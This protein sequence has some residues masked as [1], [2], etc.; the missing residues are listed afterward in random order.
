[1]KKNQGIY[2]ALY[3]KQVSS[4]IWV[5]I[6]V[7]VQSKLWDVEITATLTKKKKNSEKGFFLMAEIEKKYGKIKRGRASNQTPMM[8]MKVSGL[9]A[10]GLLPT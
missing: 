1:M 6:H 9:C 2:I 10:I 4:Y 5:Q 7:R 3:P 8:K